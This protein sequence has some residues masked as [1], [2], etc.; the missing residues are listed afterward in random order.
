MQNKDH[1]PVNKVESGR[2]K[3]GPQGSRRGGREWPGQGRPTM[4]GSF[5][6]P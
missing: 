5:S 1:I 3:T 4:N 6:E 2:V